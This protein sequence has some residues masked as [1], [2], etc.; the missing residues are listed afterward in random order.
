MSRSRALFIPVHADVVDHPK[1]IRAA[2]RLGV[3]NAQ[4]IGHMVLLWRC[5]ALHAEQGDL[6]LDAPALARVAGWEG[7][8]EAFVNALLSCGKKDGHGFL[9]STDRGL[10]LHELPDYL[11]PLIARREKDRIRKAEERAAAKSAD[12]PRTRDGQSAEV[13]SK[14]ESDPESERPGDPR[15]RAPSAPDAPSGTKVAK[16]RTAKDVPGSI[17]DVK[18][19]WAD[20]KLSGSP[21]KFFDYHTSKGWIVGKTP[22]RD[23]KA[24]ARNWSRGELGRAPAG[25]LSST[26][27]RASSPV[28]LSTGKPMTDADGTF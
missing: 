18:A 21:D 12:S 17:D 9:E 7:D 20:Q 1:T 8:P 15:E 23:W 27:P 14:S 26:P 10:V 22:M 4:V 5:G 19:Y 24:S 6:G 25:R 11:E 3:S 2:Q 13:R 28:P 16:P